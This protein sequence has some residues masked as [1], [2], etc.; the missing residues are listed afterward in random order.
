LTLFFTKFFKIL[1]SVG[2]TTEQGIWF[3]W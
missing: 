2:N 3:F 1:R